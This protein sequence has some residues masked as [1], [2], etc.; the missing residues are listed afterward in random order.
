MDLKSIEDV[1][2]VSL[3]QAAILRDPQIAPESAS[4]TRQLT[5]RLQ[6]DLDFAR[7]QAAWQQVVQRHSI[8]RASFAWKRLE[9]AVQLVRREIELPVSQLDWRSH[10]A[11]EQQVQLASFLATD[12][13]A[14][15]DPAVAPLMRLTLI[16]LA[17]SESFF[18]WTFHTLL[19]DK[20]SAGSAVG[21]FLRLYESPAG[22]KLV[23]APPLTFNDHVSWLG[24]QDL[25][26][27]ATYWQVML[28]ELA[29]P[30][31]LRIN[32]PAALTEHAAKVDKVSVPLAANTT[33]AL[34]GL[35]QGQRS[36]L[37]ALLYGAWALLLSHYSGED[38]VVFGATRSGHPEEAND[39]ICGPLANTVPLCVRLDWAAPILSWLAGIHTQL[40]GID[41]YSFYPLAHIRML[42]KAPDGDPL[43]E[44]VLV[45]DD[46]LDH[47]QAG[48][49]LAENPSKLQVSGLAVTEPALAPL[50]LSVR[51]ADEIVLELAYDE[52]HFERASITR[53][54][55][56]LQ[57]IL[58]SFATEPQQ[59]LATVPI[60][61]PSE[62]RQL[63][64]DWNQT[65]F[66]PSS[67][68]CVHELFEA[69]AELTP[70][71][72]AIASAPAQLT[73]RELNG[74]ANQVAHHLRSLGVGPEV[75]VALCIER[76]VEMLVGIL[77]ILKA[78]GAY[79]PLDPRHPPE[80]LAFILDDAQAIVLVTQSHLADN[81]PP[82]LGQVLCLDS[83]WERIA[84]ESETNPATRVGP[85]NLAYV[86]YTSGST[87]Q[88]K[89]VT[90]PHAGL[91]NLVAWHQLAY[92][93]QESDRAVQLAS[94]TF[95]ASVWEVWPYL[96]AGASLHLPDDET[97]NYPARLKQWLL[98]KS[99]T[100]CFLPTP[101][102][103]SILV[104]V[105]PEATP[106]RMVLT[107]GDRLRLRPAPDL[108]F[109]LINHYGPTE[110]TVVTTCA[111]V[112]AA[113][114]D[115]PPPIGRPI[116]NT[117]IYV[118]DPRLQPAP[119]GVPGELY[120]G[121]VGLA[122]NYL[123]RPALTAE[124]F[125]PNPFSRAPGKR[126]YRTGDLVRYRLDGQ[127]EF[128]GRLD[129]QAK[130]RGY[131]IEPGE[132]E[133]ALQQHP[134]VRE[135]VVMLRE[136]G[137][138]D[139]RLVAYVIARRQP[140]PSVNELRDFLREKLP[141]YMVPAAFVALD[142][143]PLTPNGKVDR[144]ALPLPDLS[145]PALSDSVAPPHTP[146]EEILTGIWSQVLGLDQVG[147]DDNFFA[148]GGDSIRSVQVVAK[149]QER[150]LNFSVQQVFQHQTIRQLAQELQGGLLPD[151]DALPSTA[152]FGL[153]S[154]ADR[155]K[156]PDGVKDAYPLT[157]L[158]AGMV[159]H[160]D[161][162][163]ETAVY[164][165]VIS[166]RLKARFDLTALQTAV[167]QVVS[168]HPMLR[169]A[170]QLSGFSEPLQVVYSQVQMPIS[171][172]DWRE[173]SPVEQEASLADWL[174]QEK[175]C[176]FAW[177]RAPLM[178]LQV[179]RL[180]DEVFQFTLSTHH[181][182]LDGWSDG[183]FLTELFNRYQA[184]LQGRSEEVTLPAL[185]YRDFVA[186]ERSAL[187]S[188][189]C[190]QYWEKELADSTITRLPRLASQTSRPA[191]AE[192]RLVSVG[193]PPETSAALTKLARLAAVPV[194]SVLLAAHLKVMSLLGG[195]PDVLTG[196]V[197][198]G[199]PEATDG[200]RLIGLFLNT[201]PFRRQ[202]VGGSWLD[203][204]RE[205]FDAERGLLP[206]RRYPLVELQRA[207]G[208][209]PLFE[210]A[211][212][213]VHFHIYQSLLADQALELVGSKSYSETNFT[214][215]AD[216]KVDLVTS[217]VRAWLHYDATQLSDGQAQSIAGYYA[218]TLAAM[219]TEPEARYEQFSP[220][221]A[222]ERKL[223]LE[224]WDH[225]EFAGAEI[226]CVHRMFET[227]VEQAPTAWA[228]SDAASQISYGALN[229]RS[230]QLAHA[231]S[232]IGVDRKQ[233]IATLIEDTALHITA[234]LGILKTGC[235]F[236][237][238]DPN[239]PAARLRQIVEEVAPPCL[240]TDSAS[241]THH[242]AL[243]R[244]LE[245]SGA[246]VILLDRPLSKSE[247]P[248][249]ESISNE[250]LC[251]DG[252]PTHNPDCS[253]DPADPAYIVYTS[254]STGKPKGIMQS[255][256][257]LAQYLIWQSTQFNIQ[258]PKRV[259]QWAAL[260]YDASY[261][262]IFGA[263]CCGATL[264]L[265]APEERTDSAG[266]LA[267]LERERVSLLIT[268]PS[269]CRQMLA[270][271][272]MAKTG[273]S[274]LPQLEYV[275]LAGEVLPVDL[276][277]D[278][279]STFSPS[280][281]LF[282]L[283]GPTES[284]LATHYEIVAVSPGQRAIPV[285]RAIAGRQILIL[286]PTGQLCPVGVKGEIY[287]RSPYLTLGYFKNPEETARAFL[288]NPFHND[289]PDRVYRTGDIGRYLPDGTIE[290]FGRADHQVK[291]RGM[292]IELE[293]IE[294]ALRR[295]ETVTDCLVQFQQ[296]EDNQRLVA[297]VAN[298]AALSPLS[299]RQF[300]LGLLPDYMVPAS[301]VL[302]E[303]LP[304]LPNGKVDRAALS[305]LAVANAA[306]HDYE[307]PST[308][309]ESAI[310]QIW[311]DLLLVSQ[312][313]RHDNFFYLGGHSL[314]A[315]Q[316]VN[317][318]RLEYG[319]DLPLRSLF[320]APTVAELA[321]V[322]ESKQQRFRMAPEQLAR[323]IEGIKGL[324]DDEV[325]QLLANHISTA[326]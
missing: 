212:N 49:V 47:C 124:R 143:F 23:S 179:H 99:I 187:A 299:V 326:D 94:L 267:W 185:S 39:G 41:Q 229:G 75:I 81:L 162:S 170:F 235:A 236:V 239:Y 34:L 101:L 19:L 227:Q 138:D 201:L 150:G 292:R 309:L 265:T 308:A 199:R 254:G 5:C 208:G 228:L 7:F 296:E 60:L 175:T 155:A 115:G 224:D 261:A 137:S 284:I 221:S 76:S 248:A 258:A 22:D 122:R 266:L 83:E 249:V 315:T 318:L 117:Q 277:R 59:R 188:E 305:K 37:S 116:A 200:D 274:P 295:H 262:E 209:Q 160:S 285:G 42:S 87:G 68:R 79:L 91:T 304:K 66:D 74:R 231:L 129:D 207:H 27:A 319:I 215:I 282:N 320:E 136:D 58:D 132:I 268:V 11:A 247:K 325:N 281:R 166:H 128:L 24:E 30:T 172:A 139:K 234:L 50:V 306:A 317:R 196:L 33:E 135:T 173:R 54:A 127:L 152:P 310:A 276:A 298:S 70:D 43:L 20:R 270:N 35:T 140:A 275:L 62:L 148:L 98:D 55:G 110:N 176:P 133:T 78:G 165:G 257:G 182:L 210:T 303:A 323:T 77:G 279:L 220:L 92:Q 163:P 233:V 312:V 69:Q 240:L 100:I 38:L 149:A 146:E 144:R 311:Q 15:F 57:T 218:R 238:L 105:W 202:L 204:V 63:L 252:Q 251:L 244:E 190:R 197:T 153:V 287:I 111:T 6:G 194:K 294:A 264:C 178:R 46:G 167:D 307:P 216:F 36:V 80:R 12:C 217:Q 256:A 141:D 159:F 316:S 263:L 29:S 119:L 186:L 52:R 211:F 168:G 48:R 278:W 26:K 273:A 322:I 206:F 109:D 195:Q 177:D 157:A 21:D 8:L 300:L 222:E 191:A 126:L 280:G 189:Q 3:I 134:D 86:I 142:G 64:V 125:I 103:E 67:Q 93:V 2:P 131:R 107:G 104:Q 95:D 198:N 145:R 156:L 291:L 82:Y 112:A 16:R 71:N 226:N 269:F 28:A 65:D 253:V 245:Q 84:R 113:D 130:V 301:F 147:I 158:Q 193:I 192:M 183:L 89:G 151:G 31:A 293:E 106:L 90:L 40:A 96:T 154:A 1:Y 4:R 120:I 102:A 205:T 174:R 123:G 324:T 213:F 56:Q 44:S 61:P 114:A 171:L 32:R 242:Q 14:G 169:T 53:L 288:Q 181:A 241:A 164:H 237:C 286:A 214:L 260:T 10:S 72:L 314:L 246:R 184:L 13:A 118:L 161:Y 88:P 9:Q 25:S 121:G 321:A 51:V 17:E 255:H 259:A 223:L 85:D 203:L 271:L 250:P 313:G 297:F 219:A 108:P 289:Y 225:T 283:Y 243:Y 232:S 180:S 73:Y 302:L 97:R 18:A 45:L 230:N 272:T 290:F